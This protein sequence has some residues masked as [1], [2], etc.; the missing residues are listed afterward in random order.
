VLNLEIPSFPMKLKW[1]VFALVG[2]HPTSV[3]SEMHFMSFG[4]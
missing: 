1:D 2:D 3:L 4:N